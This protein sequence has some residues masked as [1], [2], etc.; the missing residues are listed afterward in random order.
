MMTLK[1]IHEQVVVVVGASSGIG[2]A[3]ALRFAEEGAKVVLAARSQTEL[4]GLAAEITADG[5]TALAVAV[6]VSEFEQVQALAERAATEFGRIDT[7]VHLAGVSMWARFEDTQPEEFKRII[8]VNLMGQVYG[9]MAA[10]PHLRRVGR[11][12]LIHV[13]SGAGKRALPLQSAYSSSKHGMVGFLEALRVELMDEGMPIAVTNIQPASMNTPLFSKALTRLGV[14]PRPVKPVYEPEVVAE[15]IL[16]AAENPMREIVVGGAGKA[17]ELLQRLSPKVADAVML[18]GIFEGQ[19]SN[20]PKT[21]SAPNNL[22]EHL[23]GYGRIHGQWS[24]EAQASS[25]ATWLSLRPMVAWGMMALAAAGVVLVLTR[26][27]ARQ[28]KRNL[29]SLT[30]NVKDSVR[31]ALPELALGRQAQQA[32]AD[33]RQEARKVAKTVERR[34]PKRQPSVGE[35]AAALP[36]QARRSVARAAQQVE[37]RLP[38]HQPTLGERLADIPQD[39]AQGVKKVA[40]AVERKLPGYQPTVAERAADLFAQVRDWLPERLNV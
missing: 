8:D 7:W 17:I 36:R 19:Y 39:V 35:R 13:S 31:D 29:R 32:A 11:G 5:G 20:E 34:L 2:R 37:R 25:P 12:A 4:D 6:D 38:T 1:P 21:D 40:H 3:T 18:Q 24:D 15:A 9:A 26:P 14:Q 27:W 16:Y 30:A 22:F 10:L 23:P 28:E 33:V